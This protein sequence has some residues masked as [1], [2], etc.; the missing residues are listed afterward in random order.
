MV[1]VSPTILWAPLQR[2]SLPPPISVAITTAFTLSRVNPIQPT[3]ELPLLKLTYL[4]SELL[5]FS[6]VRLFLFHPTAFPK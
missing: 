3:T 1:N 6:Q 2:I 4:T 5:I